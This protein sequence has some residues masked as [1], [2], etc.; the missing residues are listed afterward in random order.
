MWQ[1]LRPWIVPV[2]DMSAAQFYFR[3]LLIILQLVAAYALSGKANPF[4]Y[5]GF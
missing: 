5:Q 1:R 3:L 4:F 2:P